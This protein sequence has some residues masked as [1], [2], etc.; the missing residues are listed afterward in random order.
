MSEGHVIDSARILKAIDPHF[1][2]LRTLTV[3]PGL[4]LWET[5]NGPDARLTSLTEVQ[6]VSEIRL[7]IEALDGIRS[8]LVSDHIMNLLGDLEGQFPDDKQG[9]LG[10][11]D[12]FLELPPEEQRLFQAGR[13]AGILNGVRNLDDPWV[14]ARSASVLAELLRTCGPGGLEEGIRDLKARFV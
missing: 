4:P 14:R 8:R 2:R 6:V 7:L 5:F 10:M 11:C 9:L 3:G 1:I 13:R 12:A